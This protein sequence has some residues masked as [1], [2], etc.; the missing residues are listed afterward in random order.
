MSKHK[1]AG[2]PAGKNVKN[3]GYRTGDINRGISVKGVSQIGS[4]IGN[5]VTGKSKILA[6]TSRPIRGGAAIPS[7]LGNAVAASTVCKPGGSRS[8]RPNGQQAQH[9]PVNPG[10]PRIGDTKGQWPDSKRT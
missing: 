6:N 2:G 9:G 4:A 3:V 8:V 10:G 1:P 7:R 5:H